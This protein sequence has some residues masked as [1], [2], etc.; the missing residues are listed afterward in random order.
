MGYADGGDLSQKI[1]SV[2]KA[3]KSLSEE[4]V[5]DYF[6]Q[7]CL[8]LQ[9]VH[10]KR[11]LHR[12]LKTQARKPLPRLLPLHTAQF[13]GCE[14]CYAST[15]SPIAFDVYTGQLGKLYRIHLQ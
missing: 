9:H 8:A 7:I 15:E 10:D 3:G 5:L 2:K 12:D 4:E 14:A 11:I 13:V 6:V 1:Q